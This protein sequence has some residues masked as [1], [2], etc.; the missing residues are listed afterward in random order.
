MACAEA[1]GD[2]MGEKGF[3]QSVQDK[4]NRT[5]YYSGSGKI[6]TGTRRRGVLAPS[7]EAIAAAA[8]TESGKK[9]RRPSGNLVL[10]GGEDEGFC[11]SRFLSTDRPSTDGKRT[12][13]IV[14]SYM[15]SS[16][17]GVLH[18]VPMS[19]LRRWDRPVMLSLIGI[20]GGRLSTLGCGTTEYFLLWPT[21]TY[22]CRNAKTLCCGPALTSRTSRAQSTDRSAALPVSQTVLGEGRRAIGGDGS[23]S[24]KGELVI[25]GESF[26]LMWVNDRA[27]RGAVPWHGAWGMGVIW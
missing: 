8:P 25:G 3:C 13:V 11:L 14:P 19:E 20:W 22:S 16:S 12:P 17:S 18:Q 5:L 27:A 24:S 7:N 1:C 15:S 6:N 23:L 4:L 26:V 2:H 10:E 21:L 9:P